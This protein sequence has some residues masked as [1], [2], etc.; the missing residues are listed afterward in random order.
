MNFIIPA[1][2]RATTHYL[3]NINRTKQMNRHFCST[4]Y[5]YNKKTS[6]FLFINHKKVNKWLAPGGHIEENE[7][8]ETA[9]V[10]EVKE[11]TGLDV[12]LI[13]KRFPEEGDLIRP[14]GIQLNIVKDGEHEHFDLIY[15][16][17][18]ISSIEPKLNERETDGINWFT[19]EEILSNSFNTF[20]KNR[21]WCKFFSKMADTKSS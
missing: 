3:N 6:M 14:Y 8:P 15:L 2:W 7:D 10:R 13:G 20:D 9:A 11:E 19:L 4:V 1:S 16:A 5:V 12:R 21:V 17:F 18:P